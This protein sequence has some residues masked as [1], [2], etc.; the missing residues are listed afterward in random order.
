MASVFAFPSG[1]SFA[2]S[3]GV[4]FASPSGLSFAFSSGVPVADP[5]R[6][7]SGPTRFSTGAAGSDAGPAGFDAGFETD[8]A[9]TFADVSSVDD[10]GAPFG[11]TVRPRGQGGAVHRPRRGPPLQG[12]GAARPRTWR[13]PRARPRSTPTHRA[14]ARARPPATGRDRSLRSSPGFPTPGPG[15]SVRT[16]GV[17]RGRVRQDRD[18]RRRLGQRWGPLPAEGVRT[19]RSGPAL[20]HD[21]GH[22]V[23]VEPGV[24]HQVGHDPL[25]SPLVDSKAQ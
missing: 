10:G 14:D 19:R 23:A 15:K 24:V 4:P 9:D 6:F 25:E 8:A 11:V 20:D 13:H 1:L 12:P 2:F 5:A 21:P 22:A 3:S 7:P 16:D 18:L 17:G